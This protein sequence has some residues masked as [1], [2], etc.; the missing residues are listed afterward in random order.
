MNKTDRRLQKM[1]DSGSGLYEESKGKNRETN[2]LTN[3]CEKESHRLNDSQDVGNQ[4][5]ESF[6]SYKQPSLRQIASSL[7]SRSTKMK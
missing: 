7:T 4:V 6:R 3:L 2:Y 1:T 5:D